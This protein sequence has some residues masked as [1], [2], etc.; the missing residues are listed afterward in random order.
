M[1]LAASNSRLRIMRSPAFEIRP[2]ISTSPDWY[3]FGVRPRNAPTSVDRLNRLGSS[4]VVT[5]ASEVIA[6][7]PGTVDKR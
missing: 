4:M 7:T 5:N 6:P 2:L 1:A 3:R